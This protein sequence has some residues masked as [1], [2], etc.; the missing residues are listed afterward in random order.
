MLQNKSKGTLSM[1]KKK[2][3]KIGH[4]ENTKDV[5]KD[6]KEFVEAGNNTTL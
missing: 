6:K 3:K 4:D 5:I 1:T 2:K